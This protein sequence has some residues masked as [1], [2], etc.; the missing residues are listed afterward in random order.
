VD[1]L[2]IALDVN[3]RARALELVAALRGVAGGFKV[4]SQLFTAEGPAVAEA[5]VSAGERLFLDLKFHDIPNTVAGAVQ[6]ATGLGAWMLTVHASGGAAMMR[7]AMDA[8]GNEAARRGVARPLIVAVTVLTSL[9]AGTLASVGVARPLEEQVVTLAALAQEA[10]LDGVVASPLEVRAIR[11]RCGPSF[12]IVT[13]GI[14]PRATTAGTRGDDQART[15]SAAE[16]LAAGSSHLVV[17]RPI[18]AA[19]EP[20][21]AAAGMAEEVRAALPAHFPSG[22]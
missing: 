14:R 13:P 6:S 18:V 21:Q 20:R 3:S 17:G 19:N 7:A 9:D 1:Q 4:G 22:R 10:G 5:V 15:L 16:A 11:A 8:A 2:L 12:L